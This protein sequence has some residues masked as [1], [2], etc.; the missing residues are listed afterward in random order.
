MSELYLRRTDSDGRVVITHHM[1]WDAPRFLE[2]QQR[3]QR[4]AQVKSEEPVRIELATQDEYR[5]FAWPKS[6][7]EK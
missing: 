1:V 6:T 7:K 4:E 2:N 5:A 3:Y